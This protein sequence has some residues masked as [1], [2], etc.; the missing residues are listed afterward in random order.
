MKIS[1][2]KT[3]NIDLDFTSEEVSSLKKVF[4]ILE[5]FQAFMSSM[6]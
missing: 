6:G 3:I 2:E 4:N 5:D 1:A